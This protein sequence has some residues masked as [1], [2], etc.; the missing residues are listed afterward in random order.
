MWLFGPPNI[1]KMKANIE[2]MKA[3][4]DFKGLIKALNYQQDDRVRKQAADALGAIGDA[5]AVDPLSAALK[6]NSSQ[7]RK[8]VALALRKIGSPIDGPKPNATEHSS[9]QQ[10][11]ATQ[12]L[13][14]SNNDHIARVITDIKELGRQIESLGEDVWPGQPEW[15]Q[16]MTLSNRQVEL[17]RSLSST[18]LLQIEPYLKNQDAGFRSSAAY[19][20]KAIHLHSLSVPLPPSSIALLGVL[21]KDP[22]SRVR[23]TA[24][25]TLHHVS[26]ST[27]IAPAVSDLV[28][29]IANSD[30]KW[31]MDVIESLSN[32]HQKQE[33]AVKALRTLATDDSADIA[34]AARQALDKLG[35]SSG[36]DDEK[37]AVQKLIWTWKSSGYG[38]FQTEAAEN[39]LKTFPNPMAVCS[40]F[41]ATL[42]K[43]DWATEFLAGTWPADFCKML[44]EIGDQ[45][46]L[47]DLFRLYRAF[48]SNS[49]WKRWLGYFA[50]AILRIKGG[51]ER[52]RKEMNE[53]RSL[54]FIF[55]AITSPSEADNVTDFETQMTDGEKTQI[56]NRIQEAEKGNAHVLC[57]SLRRVGVAAMDPLLTLYRT[58]HPKEAAAALCGISGAIEYLMQRVSTEE[59]EKLI[60]QRYEYT[61]NTWSESLVR[62]M[63]KLKTPRC[64]EWLKKQATAQYFDP[65]ITAQRK[66]MIEDLLAN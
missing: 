20:I 66:A 59:I 24:L 27:D 60:A 38:R 41:T 26:K 44:A 3:K 39:D 48:E 2:K 42:L 51:W 65:E 34:T 22:N 58:C 31:R 10:S 29:S 43:G 50:V 7:V 49:R 45:R 47:D 13:K 33:S 56:I 4:R 1:E 30:K 52:M 19:I 18:D 8:A 54:D 61:G 6:D 9:P 16:L 63:G 35:V 15:N 28:A 53:D 11:V 55:S 14:S 12:N 62:G 32:S 40:V 5:C 25:D 57:N 46:F 64:I 37:A 17:A 36:Q 23:N 21:L